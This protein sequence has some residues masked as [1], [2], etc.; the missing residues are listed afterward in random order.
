MRS[1]SNPEGTTKMAPR[2]HAGPSHRGD[3]P[4]QVQHRANYDSAAGVIP[5]SEVN[6]FSEQPDA[7]WAHGSP[8][9]R[10]V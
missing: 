5:G 10:P 8:P 2:V 7:K 1:L 4:L 6:S 3:Y 9:D